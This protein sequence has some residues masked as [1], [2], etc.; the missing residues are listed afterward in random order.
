MIGNPNVK[1]SATVTHK[2]FALVES[3]FAKYGQVFPIKDETERP[4]FYDLFLYSGYF[5]NVFQKYMLTTGW[6]P[7]V[8]NEVFNINAF[9]EACENELKRGVAP[10]FVG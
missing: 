1:S 8:T 2:E 5:S 7:A 4:E 9:L 3:L 10:N 6:N